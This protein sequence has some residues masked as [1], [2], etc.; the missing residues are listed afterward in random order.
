MVALRGVGKA[1]QVD[2]IRDGA[3]STGIQTVRIEAPDARSLPAML[4]PQVRQAMLHLSRNVRDRA[5][6]IWAYGLNGTTSQL[7]SS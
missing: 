6:A 7:D 5:L 1:V 4:A 2:G 3:E